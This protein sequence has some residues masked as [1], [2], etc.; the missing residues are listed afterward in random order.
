MSKIPDGVVRTNPWIPAEAWQRLSEHRY[1]APH[2]NPGF[3]VCAVVVFGE[4]LSQGV[5][6]GNEDELW[7]KLFEHAAQLAA[8]RQSCANGTPVVRPDN[9]ANIGVVGRCWWCGK[10]PSEHEP[11]PVVAVTQPAE[12][13]NNG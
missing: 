12:E 4:T 6:E 8:H 9:E 7:P 10:W 11:K 5:K 13:I 2:G 3:V 1:Q